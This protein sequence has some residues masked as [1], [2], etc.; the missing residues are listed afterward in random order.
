MLADFC[1][2]AKKKSR[3]V[4]CRLPS[5]GVLW[6]SSGDLSGKNLLLLLLL[7]TSFLLLLL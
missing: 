4:R 3:T 7:H 5:L 2:C 1:L 6:F